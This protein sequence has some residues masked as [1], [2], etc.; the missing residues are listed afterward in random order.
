MPAGRGIPR[1]RGADASENVTMD[2]E[3]RWF[4]ATCPASRNV[5]SLYCLFSR[6]NRYPK[7]PPGFLHCYRGSGH[8]RGLLGA[9]AL[10]KAHDL[11]ANVEHTAS[12]RMETIIAR[13][14]VVVQWAVRLCD[15]VLMLHLHTFLTRIAHRS[16]IAA[17][18]AQGYEED[19]AQRWTSAK[20]QWYI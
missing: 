10:L 3:K 14:G 16:H 11:V 18:I 19:C 8:F 4:H 9:L 2:S 17:L 13:P 7:G 20:H 12:G 15:H 5:Q 6:H 1:R